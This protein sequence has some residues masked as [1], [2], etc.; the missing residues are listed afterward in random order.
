MTLARIQSL[1]EHIDLAANG[2]S[3]R[4]TSSRPRTPSST[5]QT[6]CRRKEQLESDLG[7][8]SRSSTTS[9][10]R[11]NDDDGAPP[12]A[13]LFD[14]PWLARPDE[15]G[16]RRALRSYATRSG[17]E[18]PRRSSRGRQ[19][20]ARRGSQRQSQHLTGGRPET[21]AASCSFTRATATRTSS[22]VFVRRRRRGHESVSSQ[23]PARFC[24]SSTTSGRPGV[25][26]PPHR[27]D[28]PREPPRVFGELMYLFEYRD[29]EIDLRYTKAFSL[30]REP[31]IHRDDEHR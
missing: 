20:R 11:P 7:G 28:E 12:T 25:A 10:A 17:T 22:R 26:L 14:W 15:L 6:R 2:D 23:L 30:P 31:A 13:T 19:A 1:L 16:T 9:R 27:R 4:S 24:D 3:G 21:R 5:R 18:T 8:S 29:E